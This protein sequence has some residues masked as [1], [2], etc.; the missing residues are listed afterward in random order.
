[1]THTR[2]PPGARHQQAPVYWPEL[3]HS[4]AGW[5]W[6]DLRDWVELFVARFRID[7]R[8]I[9]PCWYRHN[10]MVEA[11]SALYDHELGSYQQSDA[12]RTAVEWIRAVGEITRMLRDWT[13]RAGCTGSEHRADVDTGAR[14]D[15]SE[16]APVVGLDVARRAAVPLSVALASGN[17]GWPP[18]ADG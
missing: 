7:S 3:L 10:A 1:V 2:R 11:L 14:T 4:E 12:K 5:Q 17:D 9:P 6:D 8:T 15:E 16:W 18:D 13:A